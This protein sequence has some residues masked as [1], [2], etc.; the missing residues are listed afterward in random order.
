[1]NIKSIFFYA[2][3]P[4]F[5]VG[6]AACDDSKTYAELLVEENHYVNNFLADHRVINEIPADTV[7][8]Y[9]A[10][11]PYYRLDEDGQLY[12]QVIDPGTPG[13]M[14]EKNELLYFLFTRYNLAYYVD[15]EFSKSEG[16]DN[17]L[18]GNYSFRFGNYELNS[19]YSFGAG[20]QAPL[21]YLPVDCQVNIVIKSQYGMPNEMSYV[22]PY[23]YSIRYFRP[24]I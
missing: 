14:V 10:N 9:G 13:N 8:E 20:I 11:A 5:L 2:L 3:A 1:M 22:I 18:G 16:N 24:K 19:S 6:L 7:F 4:L 21:D 23:L 17:V 12:M 15:G